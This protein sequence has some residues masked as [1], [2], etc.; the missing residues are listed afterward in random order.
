MALSDEDLAQIVEHLAKVRGVSREAVV[1]TVETGREPD[2]G[3]D[4]DEPEP[5]QRR[6][7]RPGVWVTLG[8]VGAVF[9]LCIVFVLRFLNG[10]VSSG[11]DMGKVLGEARAS[12]APSPDAN[13]EIKGLHISFSYPSAFKDAQPVRD[14]A[15]GLESYLLIGPGLT[16]SQIAVS[17][18]NLPSGDLKD[19]SGYLWR[20]GVSKDYISPP[21]PTTVLGEPAQIFVKKDGTERTLY[22]PHAGLLVIVSVTSSTG[23][24]LNGDLKTVQ[25]SLR[26]LG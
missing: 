24:D 5:E 22:W 25:N 11:P 20:F 23:G 15:A 26:W 2:G 17:V 18:V 8:V 21:A 19:D 4:Q 13:P 14:K 16:S 10:P 7:W 9:G 1:E 6:G 3:F 12:L